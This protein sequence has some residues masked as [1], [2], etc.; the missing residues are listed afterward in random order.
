MARPCAAGGRNK[1]DIK[2]AIPWIQIKAKG[3]YIY[4]YIFMNIEIVTAFQQALS[5]I[6][7]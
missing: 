5:S 2:Q 7:N 1:Q 3:S 4:I 6:N